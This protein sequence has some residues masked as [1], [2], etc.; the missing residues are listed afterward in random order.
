MSSPKILIV[1]D[2]LIT[3][4]DIKE[5]LEKEGYQVIGIARTGEKALFEARNNKPDLIIM[6]IHLAGELDGIETAREMQYIKKTPVIF[7]TSNN[8]KK[9]IEKAK[10][11]FPASF[12]SKPVRVAD[13]NANIQIALANF[14]KTNGNLKTNDNTGESI[15]IPLKNGHQRL[16]KKDIYYIEA[17]GS[18]VNIL[19]KKKTIVLSTNLGNMQKQLQ[20]VHFIRI[21]RKH[22]VNINHVDRIENNCVITNSKALMIG[23]AYKNDLLE[24]IQIIKTK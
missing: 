17:S 18:Y 1:E 22:I 12:L 16:P 20:C 10:K 14:E 11:S 3:A 24:K 23:D 6:D 15:Y 4:N 2:E 5:N 13:F 7:L 8:E 9:V 21:S 19:T